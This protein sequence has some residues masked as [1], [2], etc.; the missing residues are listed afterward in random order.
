VSQPPRV[1]VLGDLM[2]DIVVRLARRPAYGTDT[3]VAISPHG[4]GSAANV[5]SWLAASGQQVTYVGRTGTD[6]LGRAAVEELRATGVDVR[7]ATDG[8]LPTGICVVLV[9]PSGERTMLPDPGANAALSPHDLPD[10]VFS[11]GNHLHLSGY[12]LL[13]SGS[14][15]AA[16]AALQRAKGAGMSVSVD[17]SS[18]APLREVGAETFLNWTA[19]ADLCLLNWAEASVLAGT[20]VPG[21]AEATLAATYAEI[22]VK[23]GAAGALWRKGSAFVQVDARRIAAVDTTGAGDAFA[24]GFLGAWLAGAAPDAALR[25]GCELAARAVAHVG[26]RPWQDA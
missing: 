15:A 13:N 3:P 19:H 6:I 10:D 14:R 21:A 16:L 17:P 20:G 8:Q 18:A 2:T 25:A 23:L 22:V 24:A 7:V 5:A 11:H 26:A 9:D 4:G 12:T 1:V